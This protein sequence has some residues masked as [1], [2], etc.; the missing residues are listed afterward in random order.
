M[1]T[2]EVKMG[3]KTLFLPWLTHQL[4]DTFL[5]FFNLSQK[6]ILRFSDKKPH[7]SSFFPQKTPVVFKKPQFSM[8]KPQNPNRSRKTPDL[9]KKPM[10]GNAAEIRRVKNGV[11]IYLVTLSVP[12][13]GVFSRDLGFFE[14]DLGFGVFWPKTGVFWRQVGFF[15]RKRTKSGVFWAKRGINF[16]GYYLFC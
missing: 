5:L 10:S 15:S 11:S 4:L 12:T 14:N 7:I 9:V 3:Y 2:E 1:P 8:K 6:I 16:L 13:L